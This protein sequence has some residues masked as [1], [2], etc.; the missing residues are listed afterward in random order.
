M[1]SRV[2]A[3]VEMRPLATLATLALEIGTL[4]EPVISETLAAKGLHQLEEMDGVKGRF[5]SRCGR[6]GGR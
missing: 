4:S 6:M 2:P 3:Q 1:S 5:G